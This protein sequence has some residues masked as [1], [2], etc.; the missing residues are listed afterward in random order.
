MS[1]GSQYLVDLRDNAPQQL[2][3]SKAVAASPAHLATRVT[4]YTGFT[5]LCQLGYPHP[6][7]FTNGQ[8]AGRREAASAL[9]SE[10]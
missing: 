5:S 7:L 6:P 9:D 1:A 10:C 4:R 8:G 3:H 2:G